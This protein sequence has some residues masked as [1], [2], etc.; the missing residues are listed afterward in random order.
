MEKPLVRIFPTLSTMSRAAADFFSKQVK[1]AVTIQD[2]AHVALSG[3]NTPATLFQLL[4]QS[5]YKESIPWE[6]IHF[7]WADERC[8]PPED[9]ESNYGQVWQSLLSKVPVP[10]QNIHRIKGELEPE[11]AAQDYIYQLKQ[12]VTGDLKWPI[13]DYVLLGMGADGHTASLFPG[14][15]NPAETTTPAIAVTADYMG[16]PANRVTLTPLVFNSARHI[17]FLVSGENKAKALSEVL[18]GFYNPLNVPAQRIR[19]VNGDVTWII[20]RAA[21]ALLNNK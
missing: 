9:S 2:T 15:V 8:V 6:K 21:A 20:D 5:P 11:T 19:P 16:R 17:L 1:E 14:Q 13:L 18:D 3:G 10:K 7:Y 12:N 4:A